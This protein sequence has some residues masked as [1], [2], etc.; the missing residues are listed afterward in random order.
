MGTSLQKQL[1]SRL[2]AGYDTRVHGREDLMSYRKSVAA[3]LFASTILFNGQSRAWGPEGHAMIAEMASSF[4]KRWRGQFRP[5]GKGSV[6]IGA[7]HGST[8]EAR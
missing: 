1:A 6:D 5:A 4:S 2:H 3:V 7:S 8:C